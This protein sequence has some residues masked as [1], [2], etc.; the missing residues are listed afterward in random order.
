MEGITMKLAIY[1]T[2]GSG[3]ELYERITDVY[4]V[5]GSWEEILFIDDTKEKGTFCGCLMEPFEQFV[6]DFDKEEVEIA[7]ALGEPKYREMLYERV[8][9]KGYHLATLIDPTAK[10][11]RTAKIGEGVVI[12]DDVSISADAV[13]HDNVYINGMAMI[14]HNVEIGEHSQLSSYSAIAGYAVIGKKNYVGL[15]ACIRDKVKTGDSCIISMAAAVMKDVPEKSICMGNPA[16]VIA[17]N[18]SGLVFG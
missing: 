8:K 6:S 15:C 11:S 13:I 18:E 9:E 2:G 14:G 5:E 12:K 17:K 4:D 7:I 1:G 3:K 10:I 16:R